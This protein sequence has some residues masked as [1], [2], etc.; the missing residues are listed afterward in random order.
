MKSFKSIFL[1]AATLGLGLSATA[2]D[3]PQPS[4]AASVTQ[5]VGLT[6][7]TV[8]Y[9]RP[10][11]KGRQI[12]DALVPYSEVWRTGANASTKIT[13]STD[14]TFGGKEVKAGT[15]SLFA[16]PDQIQWT[17]YLNT[18]LSGW[19]T[20]GYDPATN[21]AEFKV[22][23]RQHPFTERMQFYFSEVAMENGTLTL[24]WEKL[25]VDMKIKVNTSKMAMENIEKA[26]AENPEDARVLRNA[27]SYCKDANTN[28][29]QGLKWMEKS[30]K[31]DG[32]SWYS[33]FILAQLQYMN[34]DT[35]TAK[36]TANKAMEMGVE[37][38]K[39]DGKEFQYASMIND[40]MLDW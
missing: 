2:Q 6:E 15:Y 31:I 5:T 16:K 14:V 8:D 37:A 3:L 11:V 4:P 10:G 13:F 36:K 22:N 30:V 27:A 17:I 26:I 28:L 9:S 21:V 20:G 18:D 29:E 25:A 40:A 32:S 33:H 1:A 7:I 23:S 34:G 38:A 12:W 19:G 39:K 24:A 35:K